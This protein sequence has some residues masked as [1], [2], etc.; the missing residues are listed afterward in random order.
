MTREDARKRIEKL[1]KELNR[2]N[3]YYYVLSK[4]LISD[5]EYDTMMHE[6][7]ELEKRYPEFF[8]PNSP[9][10][11][12]GNDLNKEFEQAEHEYP[13][14]SLGNTYSR[15]EVM[16]FDQ[17]I[18]KEVHG[19]FLYVCELKYDGTAI[20]LIY[21]H[22]RLVQ[23]VTRGDGTRGD[24]VTDNIKTIRS[25]PL[26]L[27]GDGYPDRFII[28]GEVFMPFEG[29][30]RLN[31]ERIK[32]GEEPFA[33][34]RNAAAGTLKI[35]NSSLVAKRPLDCFLYYLLGEE[36]PTDSH[37]EN[38]QIART[39][40]FKV[41][42]VM[43]RYE[44][45]EEIF[46]FI[47]RWD[48]QRKELPYATDGVV[49]KVDSLRLQERLGNTAKNPRWAIAYKFKAEQAKTRLLSVS[50]QVGR[51]GAIT[52]VANLEPVQLA[53]TVVKRA[54]L[55]NAD[56]IKML[57][58]HIGDTVYVEKGGEIIPKITGV[59]FS[60]RPPDSQPVE[61]VRN[62][63]ACGTPLVRKEGEAVYYCP[64][65]DG[66][67]PQ[68]K[69]KIEHF[70]SRKAMNIEGLGEETIDLLFR[71]GLV[72]NITD[73]YDLRPD[74][75]SPLERLG[76]KSAMNIIA[77]IENSKKVP[78]D[79][80]LYALGIRYVGE[81]VAKTLARRFRSVDNLARATFEELTETEEIGEKIAESIK[82]WFSNPHNLEIIRK[83]KEK[84]IPLEIREEKQEE[85]PALLNGKTFVVSGV[86]K[87]FSRDG[88]KEAIEKY[89]GKVSSSVS[90]KTTFL[91][92]GDKPGPN[93]VDKARKLGVEIISEETFMEMLS[94][95]DHQ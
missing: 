27:R 9:S 85:I 69:G 89:G 29:F 78:F 47:D 80:V 48:V 1:R 49:L 36:L 76:E 79:R 33:N 86:F 17:R 4:P 2:H 23:A 81:T 12:V 19:P 94:P 37:Y 52:P 6:L 64:N 62:C 38:L 88:I 74:Q 56:Q 75:L 83:L 22:G 65:E 24:V 44:H 72:K 25:I 77:S 87:H 32:N 10:Q 95:H 3:Y 41:P 21:E 30:N 68:I 55:Y 40:G 35:Q 14:L 61:F 20:S 58:L 31:Q 39:W 93:K 53:G 13:M 82:A 63:P 43:E 11:R 46:R 67:P 5:F 54:S 57:D 90:S 16:E 45:L 60:Q 84:G 28:R 7:I 26:I 8:D 42:E 34:P 18:R 91:V 73:L 50:F 92:T 51:T 66:C 71:K 15:E 70:I 59:D